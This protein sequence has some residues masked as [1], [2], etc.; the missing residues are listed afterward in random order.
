VI[1]DPAVPIRRRRRLAAGLPQ[2]PGY[3]SR[4]SGVVLTVAGGA[5]VL[6]I[7][8]GC[9][10]IWATHQLSGLSKLEML[11]PKNVLIMFGAV[12]SGAG[13]L[14][15]L[16]WGLRRG[17]PLVGPA[18]ARCAYRRLAARY[19]DQVVVVTALDPRCRELAERAQRQVGVLLD[20]AACQ[21]GADRAEIELRLPH[22]LWEIAEDLQTIS[23]LTA[24]ADES[25][26]DLDEELVRRALAAITVRVE[27]LKAE[28]DQMLRRVQQEGEIRAQGS[29]AAAQAQTDRLVELRRE[30]LLDAVARAEARTEIG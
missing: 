29:Q 21:S 22:T 23:S 3:P 16:L 9:A 2:Y 20:G 8:L 10:S 11:L 5:G 18:L 13:A 25:S 15:L 7:S 30:A 12:V 1:I 24:P 19:R 6:S 14:F 17:I 4:Y 26:A 28:A 27:G